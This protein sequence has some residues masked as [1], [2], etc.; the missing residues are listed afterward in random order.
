MG[1]NRDIG[2]KRLPRPD[3]PSRAIRAAKPTARL[4]IAENCSGMRVQVNDL[5]SCNDTLANCALVA[6]ADHAAPEA[7]PPAPESTNPFGA[8]PA[9]RNLRRFMTSLPSSV[10]GALSLRLGSSRVGSFGCDRPPR[11]RSRIFGS[12]PTRCSPILGFQ[13]SDLGPFSA[14]QPPRV[15]SGSF[16]GFEA[17]PSGS[18][19][20]F[21]RSR[22]D[23]VGFVR[24]VLPVS[25]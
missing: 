24:A 8:A 25:R 16:A 23:A 4:Q 10:V 9:R 19:A 17:R 6:G 15:R 22:G 12:S 20:Q 18:F 5:P 21:C 3:G 7:G 2:L 14:E 13:I 11:V 1:D